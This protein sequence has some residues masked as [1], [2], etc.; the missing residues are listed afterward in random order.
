[1]CGLCEKRG[2]TWNGSEPQCGFDTGVFGDNWNCATVNAVRDICYEGQEL[3][4]SGVDYQY[5]ED[6]KYATINIDH[7]E[8]DGRPLALWVSWYKN[9]GRTD[10]MWLLFDDKPPRKPTEAECLAVVAAYQPERRTI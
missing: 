9:R 4:P 8:I 3:L 2:K 5:C 7:I 6:Q 10:A 1:M